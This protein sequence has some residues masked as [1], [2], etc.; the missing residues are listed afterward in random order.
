MRNTLTSCSRIAAKAWSKAGTPAS[1]GAPFHALVGERGLFI[2]NQSRPGVTENLTRGGVALDTAIPLYALQSLSG[3]Y[4]TVEW[5]L[6]LLLSSLPLLK[7]MCFGVRG[8][9]SAVLR[10]ASTTAGGGIS[11]DVGSLKCWMPTL[12][13]LYEFALL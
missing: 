12:V 1:T 13:L 2:S 4:K 10:V 7:S 8:F 5:L 3:L 9:W 6:K 11:G